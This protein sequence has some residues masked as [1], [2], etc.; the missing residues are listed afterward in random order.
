M[1]KIITT[2]LLFLLFTLS[3][4]VADESIPSQRVEYKEYSQRMVYDGVIE[5]IKQATISAQT[6]GRITEINFDV[7]DFVPQGSVIMRLRDKQQQAQLDTA[8]AALQEA[9]AL[10]IKSK[11]EHKRAFELQSK[12][13]VSVSAF[14]EAIANL[15]ASEQRLK[16]AEAKRQQ[17]KE[18]LDYTVIKAPFSG[19][20]VARH[21]EQGEMANVGQPLMSGFVVDDMRVTVSV[22]QRY[23]EQVRKNESA[24][25]LLPQTEAK[26][27]VSDEITIYPYADS[28]SHTFKVRVGLPGGLEGVYPGMMVK[29]AFTVGSFGALA[30][31]PQAIVRRSELT[32]VYVMNGDTIAYRQVRLGRELEDGRTEILAGLYEG[33]QVS[34]DPVRAG[35]M[36]KRRDQAGE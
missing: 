2:S 28:V 25:V 34:L 5:A 1:K 26:A 36:L 7:D 10:Y 3:F 35:I 6:S 24:Q 12:K 21:I 11:A 16:G 29:V 30:V 9:K 31:D 17:A 32:A 13:L 15:N 20:V 8:D 22:P 18:Q 19:I 33:D 23:I 14:D 27:V 4:A